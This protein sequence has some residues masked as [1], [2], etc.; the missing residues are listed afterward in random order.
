MIW[1]YDGSQYIFQVDELK[2]KGHNSIHRK[3]A[4]TQSATN[5]GLERTINTLSHPRRVQVIT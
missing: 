2:T 1:S 5:N 4:L 3:V